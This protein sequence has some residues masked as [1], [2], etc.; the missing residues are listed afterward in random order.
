M[1]SSTRSIDVVEF[2]DGVG[3]GGRGCR[4]GGAAPGRSRRVEPGGHWPG[5]AHVAARR[6]LLGRA[7]RLAGRRLRAHLSHRP[8]AAR[9]GCRRKAETGEPVMSAGENHERAGQTRALL[10]GRAADRLPPPGHDRRAASS[11]AVLRCWSFQLQLETSF[12]DLLRRAIPCI[13]IHNKYAGHVR[14]REQHAADGRGRRTATSSTSR[15]S[16]AIYR[17]TE[18]VDQR[19]RRQPQPDRLDRPPHDALPA[20]AVGRLPAGRAGG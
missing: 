18:A 19:L 9:A 5:R 6:Q 15:H 20:R 3:L 1:R 7:A 11:P 10:A 16:P 14:R 4:P 17:I 2:A 8:T 12:G 13:Q